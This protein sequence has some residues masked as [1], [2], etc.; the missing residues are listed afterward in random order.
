MELKDMTIEQLE[1][2][3]AAIAAE[4]DAPEADLDALE[5][6]ARAIKEELEQRRAA[7]AKRSEIR[8]A[9]ANG[10][11]QTIEKVVKEKRTMTLVE[12]RSSPEYIDAYA[13][14]VKSE[15][16]T[17][18]R[19]MLTTIND[20]TPNGT[21]TIPVPV[22]VE[23]IVRTAW[24]REGITSRVRKSY[25]KGNLKVGFE[26][27]GTAAVIHAEGASAISPEDLV[28][29]TVEMIPQSIKKVVQLSDEVYD[30]RGEAFLR[31]IY[32]EL[33]YRIAK[34]AADTLVAKIIACGTVSTTTCP[35][36]PA[37][38]STA[39]LGTVAAAMAN[40]SDEANNPVI[41]MNKL[42]WG[43]FKGLQAN[44]SY[45]YDVFENLPVVFNNT[46]AAY[47]AASTGDTYMIVGDLDQGA[48]MNFPNG[49]GIAFKFDDLTLKKQD[50]I[51]VL[52][53]QFV[54]I[55]VV[56]PNAFVKVTK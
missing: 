51:E 56:A 2:R 31:Y 4:L 39:T 44:G 50:L 5:T 10:D 38:A 30:L 8:A 49:D 18:V 1:E 17:E 23:D 47:D 52:G 13:N 7:E 40:L 48:L 28:L 34:K 41:M 46:I 33:T 12:L 32:D 21:A 6:E 25:L 29:G 37:I 35:G 53:R 11:G 14:Y 24:E 3:K 22:F 16:P 42:T 43:K 20:T 27:S 54:A 15:D 36:V 45:A 9:V 55:G 19:N 26:I